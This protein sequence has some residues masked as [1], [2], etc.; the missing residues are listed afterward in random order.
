MKKLIITGII[1]GFSA[2][3]FSCATM[4]TNQ[5]RGTAVGAGTGAA[6]GAILGQ[7]IG[8]DTEST[9]LGAGIGAALGG[10]TGNQVGKYMDLQERELRNAMAASEAASIQREQDVLKATFK[11]ESYFDYDSSRLKPGA[12]PELRRVA[13]ILIKYPHSRIEVAGHTDTKGSQEYNQRL[14]EQRAQAVANQLIYNGVSAQRVTAVGYGESRPIST[15][16]AMNR[17][18]EILISPVMEG[19]Y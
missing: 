19:S 9:L 14:S 10:L 15:N 1:I 2:T 17:R 6:V 18:V 13:D 3:L 16:D 5:Q 8:R 7:V 11:S 4:Q 12:Y